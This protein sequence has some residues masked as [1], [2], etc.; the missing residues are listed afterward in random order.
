MG[1][2]IAIFIIGGTLDNWTAVQSVPNWNTLISA[3]TIIL[4]CICVK[5]WYSRKYYIRLLERR[6]SDKLFKLQSWTILLSELSTHHFANDV[7]PSVSDNKSEE[8]EFNAASLQSSMLGITM[9]N[10]VH[11]HSAYIPGLERLQKRVIDVFADLVDATAKYNDEFVEDVDLIS[12]LRKTTSPVVGGG[13][14][15]ATATNPIDLSNGKPRSGSVT[16]PAAI[17]STHPT[18]LRSEIRKKRTF[19]ELAAKMSMNMGAMSLFTYN[20]PVTIR[21]KFQAKA[22]GKSLFV[23]LSR[24]GQEAITHDRLRQIFKERCMADDSTKGIVDPGQEDD[25]VEGN[26]HKLMSKNRRRMTMAEYIGKENY[27][28]LQTLSNNKTQDKD[29]ETFL[30]EAAIELF[31]PFHL[32]YVTEEQ[33]MAALCLVYKDQ[34]F[35]ATSLNDYGELHQSLRSVIDVLFWTIMVIFLQSFLQ[36]N[37]LSYILP[38]ATLLLTFSFAFGALAGNLF[39]AITFVFFMSPYEVGNKIYIGADPNTRIVGFV[40]GVSLLYTT[41][42][43]FQNEVM[44]IPNHSL[45]SEKICNLQESG[46]VVYTLDLCF[47]LGDGTSCT[48]AKIDQFMD[49]VKNH[50]LIENKADWQACMIYCTKLDSRTDSINYS[51]WVTHRDNWQDTS[52]PIAARTNLVRYLKM[53]LLQYGLHYVTITQ[54]VMATL[55]HEPDENVAEKMVRERE[56]SIGANRAGTSEML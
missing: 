6:F 54:P 29:Y 49:T 9:S 46:G 31:D 50:V 14:G 34:R 30:Y 10:P 19:W 11:T 42:N 18:A 24:G 27:S 51:V 25:D 48:Q 33:C 32:G 45:F 3:L 1:N 52:K 28:A 40:R 22:F 53:T 39:L 43:T 37:I 20:G 55:I 4:L 44:K 56:A 8:E 12:A 21:R 47:N 15:G 26:S 7:S 5:N 17:S 38:F 13:G 23:H 16:K 36:L 2:L 35:A 41:I